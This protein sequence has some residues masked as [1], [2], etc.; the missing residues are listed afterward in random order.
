[1]VPAVTVIFVLE[2]VLAQDKFVTQWAIAE[3]KI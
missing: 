2:V 1:M 3:H